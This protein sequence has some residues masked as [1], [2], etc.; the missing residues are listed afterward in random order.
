MKRILARETTFVCAILVLVLAACNL[1]LI[2]I[3][4]ANPTP[5]SETEVPNSPETMSL[6][7]ELYPFAPPEAGYTMLWMD[8]SAVVFV[9][10]GEFSMGGDEVAPSDHQPAHTVTLD[11][12]WI[13]QAEVTNQM[14]ANCVALGVCSPPDLAENEW[15]SDPEFANAPVTGVAWQ[16]AETYCEWV[17][18]RLPTEAEW[19][20][21]GRGTDGAAYPW[22]EDEPACEL[23][24]FQDC[25]DY[26]QPQTVR[27]YPLGASP[28]NLADMAGN[29][30]EWVYDWY[31]EDYY[32]TTPLNNPT[33][34]ATGTERVVRG[35]SFNTPVDELEI[36]L[37]DSL[38]PDETHEDLGFRCVLTGDAV[39]EPVVPVCTT[40]SYT[41][42]WPDRRPYPEP[43][44]PLAD[45][46]IQL[47]CNV[48]PSGDM[49]NTLGVR[50]AEGT[51]TSLYRIESSYGPITCEEDSRDPMLFNCWGA[52]LHPGSDF[53]IAI[54]PVVAPTEDIILR[55]CPTFYTYNPATDLCEYNLR[56]IVADCDPPNVVV[57]GY[58]CLAAPDG[59]GECPV[60]F[61]SGDF[62]GSPVCVPAS[63]GSYCSAAG[64]CAAV[65]PEG[66]TFDPTELCCD[67]PPDVE[68]FCPDGFY[69]DIDD[70]MCHPNPIQLVCRFF[71]VTGP[72]CG[73]V[74]TP[75]PDTQTGCWVV[76]PN[77][78]SGRC[79]DPC[80][81]GATP[82]TPCT[83]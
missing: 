23:L 5:D 66:L 3:T 67:Y 6:T 75:P 8:N 22:G 49:Y 63:G 71:D 10:G 2:P 36:Y 30:A 43:S 81:V 53:S 78:P 65:C 9:P 79:M 13:Y 48:W 50:F 51:D 60:G 56:S 38:D 33:G 68:P 40:V 55:A 61:Y 11:S 82:G 24:N 15:Y 39:H 76:N 64:A 20:L 62:E 25:L 83:P 47:Y 12:F 77:I 74:E 80:P 17:E 32:Q 69:L 34:P 26:D 37:R 41:P 54:C 35:S 73:S 45:A 16:Q 21:A 28:Y 7:E 52:G 44:Y 18:A 59:M 46:V 14:Y 42:T 70:H 4:A 27:Y 58:G 1:P 29:A 72:T 57:P 31:G 19:E